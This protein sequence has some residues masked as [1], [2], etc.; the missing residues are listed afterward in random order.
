MKLF[1]V[2]LW[3]R[4]WSFSCLILNS[5]ACGS[6][7]SLLRTS[8]RS[9]F[10]C[11][12]QALNSLHLDITCPPPACKKTNNCNTTDPPAPKPPLKLERCHCDFV[13]SLECHDGN[14]IVPVTWKLSLL[15]LK[16]LL[17]PKSRMTRVLS[18]SG[19]LMHVFP[20][21]LPLRLCLA[22]VFCLTQSLE[23]QPRCP[24]I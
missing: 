10:S 21:L 9:L 4:T 12:N 6:E 8:E 24:G 1:G 2:S 22:E 7:A 20:F 15:W 19:S 18:R 3:K 11:S 14:T 13:N 23:L 16:F 17:F 5:L